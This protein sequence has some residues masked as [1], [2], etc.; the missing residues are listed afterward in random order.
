MIWGRAASMSVV[1]VMMATA[2]G[3]AY[4]AVG[5]GL[6]ATAQGSQG[7]VDLTVTSDAD[8]VSS[9]YTVNF[10]GRITDHGWAHSGTLTGTGSTWLWTASMDSTPILSMSSEDGTVSGKCVGSSETADDVTSGA[11]PMTFGCVL[12]HAGGT[13]WQITLQ[14]VL[15]QDTSAA[16]TWTG[17]YLENDVATPQASLDG[18]L[19]Y[20]DVQIGNASSFGELQYGP[21]RFSGQI[22]IGG[23]LYTGD[24]VSGMSGY[25][26]SNDVPPL[27]VSG[28]SNGM[29]VTGTCSGAYDGTLGQAGV[30]SYEFTC[31]LAVGTAAPVTVPLKTVLL[32]G[33]GGCSYRDCWGDSAGYFV[34]G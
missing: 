9:D 20:G 27:A 2:P 31:S 19:S 22:D 26:A 7:S 4:A 33:T 30:A 18:A 8:G 3:N 13:P 6:Q 17:S 23:V 12:S 32:T 1:V 21:L 29:D 25:V 15:T 14:S 24:L 16:A 34:A 5:I 10:R 11:L 28:S